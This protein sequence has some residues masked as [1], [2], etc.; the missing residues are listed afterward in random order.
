[1][2]LLV[3][4]PDRLSDLV[5]KGEITAR[6]YNPGN[7][8]DEVHILICNDDRVD[9]RD[10]QKTAGTARLFLHNLPEHTWQFIQSYPLF[11]PWF[12]NPLFEPILEL[13]KQFQFHLLNEWAKPAIELARQIQPA[14]IRCHANDYNAYV[15][16]RI[17]KE[18][19]IPYVVS[20]HSNPDTETRRRVVDAHASREDKLFGVVFDKIEAIGVKNSDLA[21]PV[22][23]SINPYLQRV[24]CARYQVA[25][26]VLNSDHLGQKKSYA[27]HHPVRLISVGRQFRSKNP[28]NIIRAIEDLPEARL[29]LV[30]D[31]QYHESLQSLAR[32]LGLADRVTFI[33]A[34]PNDDLCAQ[35][36]EFDIFLAHNDFFGISKAMIEALLTGL[37]SI[38]NCRPGEQAPELQGDFVMLVENSKEGY[39]HAIQKLIDDKNLREQLGCKAYAHAQEHWSPAKTEAKYVEIYKRVMKQAGTWIEQRL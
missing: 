10:V 5:K 23:Q 17:K 3:I 30:G 14:L 9:S 36:P 37:P 19:G 27:L 1:M 18:L 24:G 12:L 33:R 7:L 20:L 31:G 16:A 4:I 26:N 15:A 2:K 32:E 28:E 13:T 39:S 29:T 11:N 34:I 38:T 25:Y 21:L 8:F 22:Y 6:Y 35:L